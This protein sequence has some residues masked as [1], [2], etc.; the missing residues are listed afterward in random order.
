[1]LQLLIASVDIELFTEFGGRQESQLTCTK[2]C[3]NNSHNGLLLICFW[4]TQPN[5]SNWP[6]KQK[7]KT[8]NSSNFINRVILLLLLLLLLIVIM[9][10]ATG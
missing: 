3:F 10:A 8:G 9:V 1:M 6:F 2:S 4:G 7:I 5:C